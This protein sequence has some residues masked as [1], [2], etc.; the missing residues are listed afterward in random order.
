MLAEE[1][2]PTW[3]ATTPATAPSS[4]KV[5]VPEGSVAPTAAGVMLTDTGKVL[6]RAGVVVDGT[7]TVVVE[8]LATVKETLGEIE[9][10]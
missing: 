2:E 4:V 8:V 3:T 10:L 9:L 1:G 5:T 7:T 6:P